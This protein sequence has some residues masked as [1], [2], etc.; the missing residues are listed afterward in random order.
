M[1]E[2]VILKKTGIKVHDPIMIVGLPGIGS[3]GKIVA[4][5]LKNEFKAVK[6]ATLYSPHFPHQVVM[7]KN[8]GIRLVS[9]KFYLIK[10]KPNDLII[11]TGDFQALSPEG[12][13]EVN[14]KIVKFFK[15]DLK[16]NF[17]YTLGGYASG[18]NNI[19]KP[20]VF[21]NATDKDVVKAHDGKK[22]I[23]AKSKGT[24]YG[25]AGMILAFAKMHKLHG[26][27][28]MGEVSFM[29]F[30]ASAA[31]VVMEVIAEIL[32]LKIN[33]KN[34]DDMIKN[35]ASAVKAIEDQMKASQPSE[36]NEVKLPYIR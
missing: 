23:F 22:I 33:M 4:E 31:K 29:D 3:V 36:G 15:N 9:N 13:Y 32:K 19:S 7:T 2:T 35:A 25:S 34:L 17:I 1:N 6:I 12:Q 5:H 8:G 10:H 26:L 30:D 27:C 20:R 14:A 28:V 24:I 16:G 11:L 21:G 18:D